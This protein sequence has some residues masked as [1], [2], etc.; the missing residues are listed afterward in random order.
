MKSMWSVL[1]GPYFVITV[2]PSTIGKISRCTPS[3]LT[4]GPE[5]EPFTATLSISSKKTIPLRS[6][7]CTAVSAT[8]SISISFSA[9]SCSKI[10][11]ATATVTLRLR[12]RFG[13][14]LLIISCRLSPILSRLDPLNIPTIGLAWSATSRSIT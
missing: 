14:T 3:R 11:R 9:S 2:E 6:A 13:I 8:S 1:T 7:S 4:S 10:L 5:L 12:V